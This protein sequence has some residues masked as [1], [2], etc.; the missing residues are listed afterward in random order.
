MKN[1]IKT[2]LT[3]GLVTALGAGGTAMLASAKSN[4]PTAAQNARVAQTMNNGANES[5][6]ANEGPEQANE[7]SENAAD[8]AQEAQETAQYQALAKITLQQAQ[9]VAEASQ[10]TAATQTELS[11][12]DSS[13]VYDV[14]FANA[15]ITV[16]AGTGQILKTEA[17]GQEQNDATETPIQGSI[18]VPDTDGGN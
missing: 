7:G 1:L 9:Q 12:D 5:N 17:Q 18:Q 6:E 14:E 8:D 13:L 11:V 2:L 15:E 4:A 3:F 16:D 10:G